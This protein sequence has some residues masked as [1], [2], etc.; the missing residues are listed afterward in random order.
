MYVI[1]CIVKFV[2]KFWEDFLSVH[3]LWVI[4]LLVNWSEIRLHIVWIHSLVWHGICI[5]FYI[6]MRTVTTSYILE[7]WSGI[8]LYDNEIILHRFWKIIDIISIRHNN[9][10]WIWKK[11]LWQ[12]I[13]HYANPLTT[14]QLFM[15]YDFV[16][17]VCLCFYQLN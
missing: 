16:Y 3:S 12:Y 8:Y 10:N 11:N 15:H 7:R 2:R 14:L 17:A 5:H 13:Y 9:D 1:G 4:C 6:F